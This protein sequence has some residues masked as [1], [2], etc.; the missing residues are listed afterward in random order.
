MNFAIGAAGTSGAAEMPAAAAPTAEHRK[1]TEAAQQFEGMFLQEML[2]PMKEHGFCAGGSDEDEGGADKDGGGF[3]DTLSGYGT[4]M[5]ATAIAK[6]GGLGIARRVVE[7]VE[8]EK[9]AHSL[10]AA[11]TGEISK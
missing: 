2:K 11:G 4:E 3:A 7:Q 5:L 9:A 8:G 10:A 1:L 6:A